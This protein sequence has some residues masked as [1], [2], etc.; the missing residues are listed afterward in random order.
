LV[1]ENLD[2]SEE[3]QPDVHEVELMAMEHRRRRVVRNTEG[4][5]I[6]TYRDLLNPSRPR[7]NRGRVQ[8]LCHERTEFEAERGSPELEELYSSCHFILQECKYSLYVHVKI[9]FAVFCFFLHLNKT[10]FSKNRYQNIFI[11]DYLKRL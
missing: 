4:Q 2:G 3:D 10:F 6:N 7:T 8:N 9:K 11:L 5:I 1:L